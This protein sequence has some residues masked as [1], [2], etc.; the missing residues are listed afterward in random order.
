M[1]RVRQRSDSSD[2][3]EQDSA[4][5]KEQL[6]AWLDAALEATFPAS[7]PVASPPLAASYERAGDAPAER[8]PDAAPR[9]A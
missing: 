3:D 6:D 2:D 9:H 4:L 5:V 1:R 7:D 8:S